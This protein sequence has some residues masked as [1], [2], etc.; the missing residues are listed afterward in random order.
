MSQCK[1]HVSSSH[2]ITSK[3]PLLLKE[4]ILVLRNV[5][6]ILIH[7]T[8]SY[9][10]VTFFAN[11]TQQ[12]PLKSLAVKQSGQSSYLKFPSFPLSCIFNDQGF[13]LIV[14]TYNLFSIFN[15]RV[16][17]FQQTVSFIFKYLLANFSCYCFRYKNIFC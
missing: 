9:V 1:Y 2:D 3:V 15:D 7:T 12:L 4:V 6:S 5:P 8:E 10:L 16:L 13:Y 17:L 11:A 14:L